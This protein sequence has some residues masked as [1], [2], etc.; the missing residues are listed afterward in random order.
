MEQPGLTILPSSQSVSGWSITPLMKFCC[1]QIRIS[2]QQ[3]DIRFGQPSLGSPRELGSR[4]LDFAQAKL[5]V[6][7]E[8]DSPRLGRAR[9]Q[10]LPWKSQGNGWAVWKVRLTS[11]RLVLWFFLS[12]HFLLSTD[13]LELSEAAPKPILRAC[14]EDLSAK[15]FGR[16]TRSVQRRCVPLVVS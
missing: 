13:L 4:P 9:W 14:T 3:K 1:H 12:H 6:R 10:F 15:K 5:A 8:V 2:G 11:G 16:L 7:F